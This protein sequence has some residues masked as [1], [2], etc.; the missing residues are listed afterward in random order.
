MDDRNV[1]ARLVTAIANDYKSLNNSIGKLFNLTTNNKTTLVDALNEVNARQLLPG[2]KGDKGDR[3]IASN[4]VDGKDGK[5]GT[6]G[7]DGRKGDKGDRG[8]AF[9][10]SHFSPEQ[11]A[12]LTGAKGDTFKFSDLTFPEFIALQRPALDAAETANQATIQVNQAKSETLSVTQTANEKIEEINNM[13]EE[14]T[15][16]IAMSHRIYL[17]EEEYQMLV[18]NSLIIDYVEYNVYS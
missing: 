12:I 18:D 7:Q 14:V 13:L 4:G 5:D 17:S 9:T 3:G 11:I 16:V 6:N 15:D 8:E 1:F 2:P 10:Y